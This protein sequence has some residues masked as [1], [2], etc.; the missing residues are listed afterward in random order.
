M[1]I[2][3]YFEKY[4]KGVTAAMSFKGTAIRAFWKTY[5]E[6][7]SLISSKKIIEEIPKNIRIFNGFSSIDN[8]QELVKAYITV[9]SEPPW[10]EQWQE[11]DVIAKLKKDTDSDTSIIVLMEADDRSV[12]GFIWAKVINTDELENEAASSLG[13]APTGLNDVIKAQNCNTLIF[14]H[15]FAV[16]SYARKGLDRLRFMEY[17]CFKL[18][19]REKTCQSIFWSTPESKIVNLGIYFGWEDIYRCRDKFGHEI[20]FYFNPDHRG[21]LKSLEVLP[22]EGLALWTLKFFSRIQRTMRCFIPE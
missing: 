3:R 1:L 17:P 16:L 21:F 18:A 7:T 2:S 19:E 11:A 4:E 5:A 15:E 20:I 22:A 6:V 8:L 13:I 9:Y 12:L 10:N 14:F